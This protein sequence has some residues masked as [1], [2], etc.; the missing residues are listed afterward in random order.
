MTNCCLLIIEKNFLYFYCELPEITVNMYIP[1]HYKNEN[2]DE[3]KEFLKVNSFGIL[4][5][6]H[7]AAPWA[8]H[9]PLELDKDL[10][11]RDCLVGHISKANPQW[12]SFKEDSQVLCIFNGPH[13]YV[14]SSWYREEEVPTWDYIAVHVYGQLKVQDEQEV[15]NSLEKLMSKYESASS[16]PVLLSALSA[17]TMRQLKGIVGFTITIN[18]IQ[19]AYKLSQGRPSDHEQIIKELEL[20]GDPMAREVASAIK[21]HSPEES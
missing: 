1:H 9:I 6:Q 4:V 3:I 8:T 7:D 18:D 5:T 16:S 11:G 17:K 2:L 14:S 19:A 21:K 13:S 12:Q 10:E 20:R 15:Y